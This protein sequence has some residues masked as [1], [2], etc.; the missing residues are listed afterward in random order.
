MELVITGYFFNDYFAI[1]FKK[2]KITEV[3][4][5]QL[6]IEKSPNQSLQL[7]IQ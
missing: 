7:K 4:Q 2:H 3:I 6:A 1:G 5:Q